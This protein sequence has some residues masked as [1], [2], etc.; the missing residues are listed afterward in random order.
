VTSR[1]AV[2]AFAR[3]SAAKPHAGGGL[4]LLMEP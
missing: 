3:A 4:A 2:L 1:E